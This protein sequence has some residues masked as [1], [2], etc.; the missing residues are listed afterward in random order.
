MIEIERKLRSYRFFHE[1]VSMKFED[2]TI[3]I[4][5]ETAKEMGLGLSADLFVIRFEETEEDG[6]LVAR[7]ND[8]K[9]VDHQMFHPFYTSEQGNLTNRK[10]WRYSLCSYVAAG[11]LYTIPPVHVSGT[12]E[13]REE[14]GFEIG[15]KYHISFHEVRLEDLELS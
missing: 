12:L 5:P 14:L 10:Y 2:I 6:D 13:S 4:S 3:A 8:I 9:C 7:V 11:S 1:S 15:K